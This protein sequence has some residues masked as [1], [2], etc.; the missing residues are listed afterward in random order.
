MP[1]YDYRCNHCGRSF[2]L[3]YK[4]YKDYDTAQ[5]LCAH[6]QSADVARRISRVAIPKQGRDLSGLSSNEMKNVL[7]GGDSR[8]IGQM[9]QQVAATTGTDPGTAYREAADRLTKGES[10]QSV[11]RDLSSRGTTSE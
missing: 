10:I 3:Y 5:P 7:D 6:C 4:S 1:T 9:F 2:T 8:E 11:E